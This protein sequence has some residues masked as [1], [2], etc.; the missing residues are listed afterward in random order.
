MDMALLA[1]LIGEIVADLTIEL[2]D[3]PG[4]EAEYLALKVK[5]AIIDVMSRRNYGA[6][7]YKD[8][9]IALDLENFYSVIKNVARY[10]YNQRGAEGQVSHEENYI[11]RVWVERDKL[12]NGVVAFVKVF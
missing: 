11:G 8:K 4:F 6:T 1:Q 3:E 12:F 10:D 5:D 2:K 7:S 9:Q